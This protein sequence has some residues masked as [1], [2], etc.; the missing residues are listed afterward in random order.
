ML[1][2]ILQPD[3]SLHVMQGAV[4]LGEVDAPTAFILAAQLVNLTA[5]G[6][7]QQMQ[8]Q[9]TPVKRPLLTPVK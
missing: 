9:A 2:I 3:G 1:R 7:V 4:L 5:Q 8:Q 6:I